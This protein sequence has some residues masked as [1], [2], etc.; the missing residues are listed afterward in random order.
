MANNPDYQRGTACHEAG[1]AVLLHSF[2][3]AVHWVRLEFDD[4][5]LAGPPRIFLNVILMTGHGR[6]I[7]LK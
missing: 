6:T 7:S 3:V 5:V 1:H 4:V 2:D